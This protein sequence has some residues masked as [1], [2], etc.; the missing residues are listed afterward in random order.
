MVSI[1]GRRNGE[2]VI[3]NPFGGFIGDTYRQRR[4]RVV[5]GFGG[6]EEPPT[7]PSSAQ[8]MGRM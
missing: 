4:K 6:T 2:S 3:E 8:Y 7:P 1:V 5:S